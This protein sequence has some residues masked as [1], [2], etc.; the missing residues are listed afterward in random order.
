MSQQFRCLSCGG[1][2]LD[3]SAEGGT[4]HHVCPPLPP[5]ATDKQRKAYSPRD[6]NISP[7]NGFMPGMIISEGKGVECLSKPGLKEPAW[8]TAL[9][10][11]RGKSQEKE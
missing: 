8:I 6:E 4:Y 5:D 10:I 9:K 7:G 3:S 11:L 2:Y 1:V